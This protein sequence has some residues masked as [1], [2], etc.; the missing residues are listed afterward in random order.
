MTERRLDTPVRPP[1]GVLIGIAMLQPFALNVLAPATPG[2]A[3]SFG[4]DYATIQLTLTLYLVTVAVIQLIVGPVSDRIG[5]RPCVLAAVGLFIAGSLIGAVAPNIETLLLARVVQAM[6]GGTCFA[7]SRAI[8]RDTASQD[9]AASLIGYVTMAMVV[10][11][12]V[13]PLIG[14]FLDA[15]YG[16]RSVFLATLALA[17]P[18]ALATYW[19]LLETTRRGAGAA[20]LADIARA[21]PDLVANRI[22]AGYCL[23]LG[24]TTASFFIF[25]AGAPYVVVEVMGR[26]PDVYGLLFLINAGGYMVG[27]FVS[28]RYGARLGSERLV[29]MGITLSV[30][31]VAL[32]LIVLALAPW[33][34]ATLFLPLLLNSFGNGMAIPGGTALALS[35]RPDLAGTAAGLMGALQLGLGAVGAVIIGYAVPVWP[36]ALVWGM[37][38]CVLV[39]AGGLMLARSP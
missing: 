17:L 1:L 6:G 38:V 4:T 13:A 34:P 3:R 15:R 12:M 19:F 39:G 7:L 16:W 36:S 24:F 14:G 25:I 33:T 11:P 28:G 20:T 18:V 23:A 31:S 32:S 10:S 37:L 35:V 2:L 26:E 22:F 9:E 8:I 21:F 29:V 30:A 5:R 27:N